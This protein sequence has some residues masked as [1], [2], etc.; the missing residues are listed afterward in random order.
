MGGVVETALK[1]RE[2]FEKIIKLRRKYEDAIESGL[3]IKRQ[4]LGKQLLQ[5]LF[6]KPIVTVRDIEKLIPV[7]FQ[8]GSSLAKEFEALG[9]F[10]EMTGHSRNRVFLL[11]EYIKL[12]IK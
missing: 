4:K 10:R 8:T 11:D 1:G 12:F 5:K 7:T 6:S 3:G 9:L 2:T